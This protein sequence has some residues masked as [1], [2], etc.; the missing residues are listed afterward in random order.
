MCVAGEGSVWAKMTQALMF[1]RNANVSR[2]NA[3]LASVCSLV[4][5]FL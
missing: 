3:T 1:S 5:Y 4:C 2:I